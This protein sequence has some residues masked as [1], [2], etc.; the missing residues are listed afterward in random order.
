MNQAKRFDWEDEADT[1]ISVFRDLFEEEV[2][3]EVN[4]SV[5]AFRQF[6]FERERHEFLADLERAGSGPTD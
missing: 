6:V 5:Q 2:Q 3:A 4:I 1:E